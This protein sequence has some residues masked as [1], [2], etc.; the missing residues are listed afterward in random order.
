[1]PTPIESRQ[2]WPKRYGKWVEQ[3]NARQATVLEQ[4]ARLG[5]ERAPLVARKA[6]MTSQGRKEYDPIIR[7][8]RKAIER[9]VALG[10]G[11]DQM[12]AQVGVNSTAYY[13][14]KG[15]RTAPEA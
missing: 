1:M 2:S 14:I 8:I 6:Y 4:L 11:H 3:P 15:G 10:L 9:G 5:A 13:K 7:K 12:R